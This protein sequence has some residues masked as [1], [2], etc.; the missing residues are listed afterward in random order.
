MKIE[1][2]IRLKNFLEEDDNTYPLNITIKLYN[3]KKELANIESIMQKQYTDILDK[4]AEKKDNGEY[5]IIG[6][7]ETSEIKIKEGKTEIAQKELYNLFNSDVELESKKLSQEEF[8][9]AFNKEIEVSINDIELLLELK[10][11]EV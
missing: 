5:E 2:L 10:E 7:G 1:T 6:T 8:D 3:I 4:Y 11:D 9:I